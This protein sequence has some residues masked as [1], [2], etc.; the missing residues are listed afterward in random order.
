MAI[1]DVFQAL[2]QKRPYRGSLKLT[3]VFE[4]MTPMVEQ[5]KLD[6]YVYGVLQADAD[7][8]Y[9]LSTQEYNETEVPALSQ[10]GSI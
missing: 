8:F 1:V 9:Q 6:S 4:I 5:G 2:T 10:H 3:E 7:S